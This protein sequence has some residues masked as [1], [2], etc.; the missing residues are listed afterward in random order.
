MATLVSSSR[1]S[2]C[3]YARR[4]FG[5]SAGLNLSTTS[6]C[7]LSHPAVR[8]AGSHTK[9]VSNSSSGVLSALNGR[10]IA[11]TVKS[12]HDRRV[13]RPSERI[14]S[15]SVSRDSRVTVPSSAIVRGE[16]NR[17]VNVNVG[18]TL[19]SGVQSTRQVMVCWAWAGWTLSSSRTTDDTSAYFI[20]ARALECDDDGLPESDRPASQSRS[21]RERWHPPDHA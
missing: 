10:K 18:P 20:R 4:S 17:F 19:N 14:N 12:N 2:L 6:T 1:F 13:G 3:V 5:R 16:P 15:N 7:E 11:S 21:Q 8:R 9:L